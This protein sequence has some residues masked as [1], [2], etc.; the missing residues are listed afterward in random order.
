[1]QMFDLQIRPH[2]PQLRGSLET[3]MHVP[4]QSA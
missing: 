4:R 3:G 2:A 1:M